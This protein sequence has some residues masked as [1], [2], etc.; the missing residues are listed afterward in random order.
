MKTSL[1]LEEMIVD[2]IM[3]PNKRFTHRDWN[4]D[5]Y[6]YWCSVYHRFRGESENEDI[7][8]YSTMLKGWKDY[9]GI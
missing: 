1:T 8:D 6:I 3:N 5:E 4:P 9:N 7:N 2:A